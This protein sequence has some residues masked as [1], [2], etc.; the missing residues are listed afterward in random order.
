MAEVV[1]DGGSSICSMRIL[2]P[3]R[4]EVRGRLVGPTPHEVLVLQR[5]SARTKLAQLWK[6][7]WNASRPA[8]VLG[9][10]LRS[11]SESERFANPAGISVAGKQHVDQ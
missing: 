3:A 1:T 2:S 10:M 7:R 6:P 5:P 11:A 9:S 8:S 4:P